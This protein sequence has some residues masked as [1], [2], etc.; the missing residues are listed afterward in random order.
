MSSRTDPAR[1]CGLGIWAVELGSRPGTAKIKILSDHHGQTLGWYLD[2]HSYYQMD[3]RDDGSTYVM[4]HK[5][6]RAGWAGD[7]VFEAMS[8]KERDGMSRLSATT[9]RCP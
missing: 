4:V 7:W 2:A 5:L 3:K 6:G 8:W 9:K 1:R